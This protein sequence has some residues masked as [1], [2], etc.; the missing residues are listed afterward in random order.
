[1]SVANLDGLFKPN[2]VAV[3][4]ATNEPGH[5]G[6]VVMENLLAGKF[7]GPV[8]PLSTTED[9]VLGVQAY[10]GVDTL[11]L[12]P[13]LA[14]LCIPPE[15]APEYIAR[16]GRRGVKAAVALCPGYARLTPADKWEVQEK[17]L[18]AAE[19]EDIRIL[20]PSGLGLIIPPIGLN[21]SLVAADPPKG[22]IAFVSQSA[23]L[24]TGVL[25]WARGHGIGFSYVV[26]LGDRLDLKYHDL[27]DYLSQDPNTR[28]ILL[29]L[30]SVSDARK[31][32][33]AARAAA[34]NKPVLVVKPGRRRG[35]GGESLAKPGQG[36]DEVY[37]EA[38]RRAGMLRV[39]EID[40]LFDA[41]Q[42]LARSQQLRG[43]RLA[44]LT[45][46]GSI[47]VM[48]ADTLIERGGQL[49]G[50]SEETSRSLR[51]LL[52]PNWLRDGI[53]DMGLTATPDHYREALT[54]LLKDKEP[55]A[56]LVMH[57]PFAAVQGE[58][59]AREVV[60][61][62]SKSQRPVF[63]CWLGHGVAEPARALFSQAGIPT[64]A[65]PDTA[66]RAFMDMAN[67]R[68]TQE[69]L[70]E[71]PASIPAGFTPDQDAALGV[72]EAVL[73]EGRSE[74]N[75]PEAKVVLAAYGVPVIHS[76]LVT[77]T[78]EVLEAAGEL[79]YP[80]ALKVVSPQIPQPFDVGGVVL[81]IED[82]EEL[83][84]AAQAIKARARKLEL[85]AHISGFIVQ[86]MGRRGA[87]EL[88]LQA[89]V[90]PVFGPYLRFGQGG[91]AAK[92]SRDKAIALPPLNMS[93]AR[94]LINRTRV[95]AFL[96]G[97]GGR[98]AADIDAICLTIIQVAQLLID[99]P[100]IQE[101]D[102][103]PLFA[104]SQGVAVL[105]ARIRVAEVMTAGQDR[106]A[107]RPYPKELEECAVLKNGR[108]VLIRPIRPEDEPAHYEFFKRLSP[109]DL[110]YRFF[111]VVR[112]LSH[113]EMTR[114]TQI[115]YEREMAFIATAPGEDGV[116]ETLGV[117]RAS[118]KPD[119]S[120]AEFAI[121]VRSDQK[122]LGLGR[123]LMEKIIRY[124]RDR[125]TGAISGQAL[126]DNK[127]MQGLA[128]KVG[129][130]VWRNTDDEVA[131]MHLDLKQPAG[132]R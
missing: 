21:A 14:I 116:N 79:G 119:N 36:L 63:T 115:D 97:L 107:I 17:L 3:I 1:M 13:D 120:V 10:K 93:L 49:S 54:A 77:T 40:A 106:L 6:R 111:G 118:T 61:A 22:R 11:P 57:V 128:E 15:E 98:A 65:T 72:V 80:V 74:L 125:G 121:I 33:S 30:E 39:F 12:T 83:R 82:P 81:D 45:N 52:G 16:L 123:M 68:R 66:V 62:C 46:G 99:V 117:V 102:I 60:K 67:H 130:E 2:S 124:C 43:N 50:F 132:V 92:L 32:M 110:R 129:F 44:I 87:Q 103:N 122:G 113:M 9:E 86:K 131:E 105:G 51:E 70:L 35:P 84:Q 56:V 76:R 88:L 19:D 38:F 24:F 42:T 7:L 95:S 37:H 94:D 34:R 5:V 55:H 75:E 108:R 126:L 100:Q 4:G 8:M 89:Q 71:M 41:A 78:Q 73:E 47:G 28:S 26:S 96:R 109:E 23:S 104:D 27:F 25:D 58:D 90:D 91:M 29:Y 101:I 31:F 85:G 48:S 114:L 18:A 59:A 127:G 112:E 20:G 53:V 69:L 64:Y